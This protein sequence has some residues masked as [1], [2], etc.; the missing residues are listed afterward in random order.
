MN[1]KKPNKTGDRSLGI[2]RD[3]YEKAFY[4]IVADHKS[5]RAILP[6]TRIAREAIVL[7]ALSP[8]TRN[9]NSL[10]T[11]VDIGCGNAPT[12]VYAAGLYDRY[13]G[14]DFASEMIG[15]ARRLTEGIPNIELVIGDIKDSNNLPKGVA[16][17]ILVYGALHHMTDMESVMASLTA[18]A[19]P[20]ANFVA[21]E[22]HC[23]NPLISLARFCRKHL[24]RYYSQEQVFFSEAELYQIL[25]LGRLKNTT[26]E[27]ISY[28]SQPFAQ[29][30]LRPQA[31]FQYFSRVAILL[32]R[33]IEPMM[34]GPLSRMSWLAVAYGQFPIDNA[35][36][37]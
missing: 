7:R 14:I 15:I 20:G 30:P 1:N 6:S 4:K 2:D 23:G 5:R 18:I 27:Y 3:A 21:I 12:A 34:V 35:K 33:V 17:T 11:L 22:P 25:S 37:S 24:D 9:G 32:D 26:V 16:D 13:I 19:K 36:S 28:F 29:V 10:G 8:L 31:L